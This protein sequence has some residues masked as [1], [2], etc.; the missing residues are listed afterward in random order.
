LTD[1]YLAVSGGFVSGG[2]VKLPCPI[3]FLLLVLR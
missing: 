2:V 3:N 1:E